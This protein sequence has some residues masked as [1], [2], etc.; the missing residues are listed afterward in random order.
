M[1]GTT[2]WFSDETATFGD[3]LAGARHAS[4]MTQVQLAKRLGVKL[5]T[6]RAW[7]DDLAEPRANRLSMLSGLLSVSLG[8]LLTGE[9]DGLDGPVAEEQIPSDITAILNEIRQLQTEARATAE[10]LGRLE[11]AMR[12]AAEAAV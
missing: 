8:W 1:T 4:G 7:E 9:G 2:D 12:K 6:L 3:R 11:K 10:R 5:K